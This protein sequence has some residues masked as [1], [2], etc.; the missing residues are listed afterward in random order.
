MNMLELEIMPFYKLTN[1]QLSLELGKTKLVYTELLE[2]NNFH[3]HLGKNVP[4]HLLKT[5]SCKYYD[6][7]L[8]NRSFV[9]KKC[10]LSLLHCNLQSS[11]RNFGYLKANLLNLNHR[12][13]LIAITETGCTKLEILSNLMDNYVFINSPPVNNRKGG[14]GLYI[15]HGCTFSRRHDLDF[16]GTLP[17]EDMWFDINDAFIVGII[18]RHPNNNVDAFVEQLENKINIMKAENKPFIICGDINIDL[19]R[20][21]NTMTQSY[22]DT[23]LSS[24]ILPTISLPTRITDHSAT[25]IDHINIYRP[26]KQIN[27]NL[28]CGNI[29]FDVSDHLPNFMFIEGN[30]EIRSN[31]PLVRIFSDKAIEK[32]QCLIPE[33]PWHDRIINLEHPNDAY[34]A[35]IN[36]YQEIFNICFPFKRISR[37]NSKRKDW[38]TKGLLIS[39]RHKN[40]LYRRHREK[41]NNESRKAAYKNYS[42]KLINLLRKAEKDFYTKLLISE[43]A[44]LQN[45]WKIYRH[46]MGKNKNKTTSIINKLVTEDGIVTG[47]TTIA[48]A[49]ND[50]F[51]TVGQKLSRNFAD[52]HNYKHYL[53]GNHIESMFFNPVTEDEVNREIERLPLNKAPGYDGIPPKLIKYTAP[54]I[55]KSL[56]H[57]YNLSLLQGCVPDQLKIAKIIP[58]YK[59][60]SKIDPGNYRPISLLS[61]FNKLLEKLVFHRLHSF[62]TKFD[63]LFKHQFGFRE[64]HSTILAII[65]I[66]DNIKEELDKGNSVI[67]TYLDLSKA[68]DTVNH[69]ILLNKL[70]HYGVRGIVHKW[71]ESY[72][73]GR[74]QLTF[75]NDTYSDLKT[76]ETGVPQGSVLGPLLFLIYVNDV[77]S[78][79]ENHNLRLF[80]DDTNLFVS[81]KNLIN[82][83]NDTQQS[84]HKLH[85]WFNDNHLTLNIDKT[86]YSIFTNKPIPQINLEINNILIKREQSV[87]YLGIYL[88]EKLNWKTHIDSV[89]TKLIQLTGASSYIS[90]FIHKNNLLQI[91]YAYIFPHIKYGIEVY[92]SAPKYTLKKLQAT[93]TRLLKILLGRGRRESAT[94]MFKEMQ[95]LSCRQIY[96]LHLSVFVYKQQHCLLPTIFD[97][98][99]VLVKNVGRRE[100]RQSQ[101]IFLHKY[102]TSQGQKTIKF[103][104]GKLWN[105]LPMEIKLA[106]SLTVFKSKCKYYIL[107]N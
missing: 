56:T 32:F 86:C 17:I 63:I 57:I 11:F 22:I 102:R 65:E 101:N 105:K 77:V 34:R 31:R 54:Y 40:R 79:V 96:E 9:S 43:K 23:L 82:V 26:L 8:F 72:L 41:P 20:P 69:S 10:K 33:T 103:N 61:I 83:F 100:T 64:N 52:N 73:T 97:N 88:D 91:Y 49:F 95:I 36:K 39:I 87:K 15:K 51:C 94:N 4:E 62:L 48:N 14:V 68:F 2:N 66:T 3:L 74:K 106:P 13:S 28:I 84:L 18:Y 70:H 90:Q 85:Q 44:S 1:Y 71:F 75:V 38:L 53:T 12:F 50:Y 46:L 45:I 59:K 107:D 6:E 47:N 27:S 21:D 80:A 37:K 104:G 78:A 60:K 42:H 93:Q 98:F 35:F 99:Y 5:I 55:I 19:L 25:I 29:F 7:E 89:C 30:D 81:G 67:G 92:G 16:G 58:I 76:I 24:N